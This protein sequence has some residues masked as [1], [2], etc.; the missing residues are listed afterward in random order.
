MITE[1]EVEVGS[2]D[3]E[4]TKLARN[5]AER[6]GELFVNQSTNVDVHG[7]GFCLM[8]RAERQGG[9]IHLAV[10]CREL[11]KLVAQGYP[12]VLIAQ[13]ARHAPVRHEPASFDAAG[14]A[15]LQVPTGSSYRLQLR[16]RA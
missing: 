4:Q 14:N 6:I 1:Q 13:S 10:R 5:I 11:G 3:N 8:V 7:K 15:T 12:F 16:V 9:M 2:H